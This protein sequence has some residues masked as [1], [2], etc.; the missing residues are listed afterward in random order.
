MREQRTTDR[1]PPGSPGGPEVLPSWVR[2]A[3]WF[4]LVAV[5]VYVLAWL[6]GGWLRPGYDPA[7]QA[8]SELFELGAPWPSRGPLLAGLVLSGLAF[9]VL[10]PALDRALP[11]E[12]RLGPALVVLAGLGTLGVVAAPCTP[13]C[14]GVGSSSFDLWH[15]I[16]AGGG[17]TALVLAPL[18][19]AWRVRVHE[20][21][22]A[23]WSVVIGGSAAVLFVAHVVGLLPGAPGLL[24]R[25]FNT[26][27]DAWY[28]FV[29]V[30]LLRQHPRAP[31]N[32][33]A[34]VEVEA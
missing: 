30:W 33:R 19:F 18:A 26:L 16:T 25:T 32:R 9:L 8:I 34:D 11:G 6:V 3:L 12:G 4:G 24:Q 14:P 5:M 1:R 29:A 20:P 27:A 15:T 7:I 21:R 17:Y 22:L 10:A 23:R 13:G 2:R 31:A 28:V